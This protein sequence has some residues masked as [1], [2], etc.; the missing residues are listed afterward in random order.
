MDYDVVI[1]GGGHNGLTAAA[2]LA[3][4]GL[5][6]QLL[7]RLGHTGGGALYSR[8]AALP[9]QLID[10]LGLDLALTSQ[11]PAGT[12][13]SLE[14]Y[15]EGA[16]LTDVVGPTLLGPL[17]LERTIADQV[18]ADTWRDLV[19]TPL[20]VAI[21]RR[22]ADDTVRGLVA[23][24]ALRG[25]FAS[26]HDP[27][28]IQNRCFLYHLVGDGTGEWKVPVGGMSAVTDALH[29]A[30]QEAGAQIVTGVGVSAIRCG[31]DSAG[32]EVSYDH[33][34]GS[35]TVSARFVLA[36]V[37]PWVLRILMGEPEDPDSKPEGAQLTITFVLDE[38]PELQSGIDPAV[39]FAGTMH[40]N[41]G[42]DQLETAYT[43]AAAGQMPTALPGE[44]TCHVVDGF[45]TLTYFGLHTPARL[46]DEDPESTKA[47][48]VGRATASIDQHLVKPLKKRIVRDEDGKRRIVARI[49]QDIERDLAM[50]GGH[51]FH[52]DLDWPWAP[53]RS[54][55]DA[56]SAR[57]GVQTGAAAVFL[58]G[59][60]ARRGGAVSG[61]GGHNAAQAV[62][63]SR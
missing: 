13:E 60:G 2:Y 24:N 8:Q 45:P 22:F 47:L 20:G 54:L 10:Q 27:S 61:L 43:Q 1:V 49:P 26:M 9:Q 15:A 35:H 58:C 57:W 19:T 56:P 53:N 41:Q 30:A 29:R 59:A 51:I 28:L 5:S 4:A 11:Q 14:F 63:E 50:P 18:D 17:P 16:R 39:A 32:A 37:A 62:L 21:E 3:R 36:N 40:L 38:L 31:D 46:F 33:D 42:Y 34:H 6:V 55:L 23:A 7:E 25:T 44:L 52:G 48:A 12:P